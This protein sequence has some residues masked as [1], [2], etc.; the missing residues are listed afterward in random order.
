MS[1]PRAAVRFL[2][3]QKIWLVCAGILLAQ[4]SVAGD[5]ETAILLPQVSF[6]RAFFGIILL[7][8]FACFAI[9]P[10]F[11]LLFRIVA[12]IAEL[13]GTMRAAMLTVVVIIIQELLTRTTKDHTFVADI[14]ALDIAEWTLM[15]AVALF[16]VKGKEPFFQRSVI[17]EP[18]TQEALLFSPNALQLEVASAPNKFSPMRGE[19]AQLSGGE[20]MNPYDRE[21]HKIRIPLLV[22]ALSVLLILLSS[23]FQF[24]FQSHRRGSSE[25]QQIASDMFKNGAEQ[26]R[27]D[28]VITAELA[29]SMGSGSKVDFSGCI[30][31]TLAECTESSTYAKANF[32]GIELHFQIS[33]EESCG[34]Q[35]RFL[36]VLGPQG[37]A[38]SGCW[39]QNGEEVATW[40]FT[41]PD[42][43]GKYTKV[44]GPTIRSIRVMPY[45]KSHDLPAIDVPESTVNANTSSRFP[46]AD[47]FDESDACL[48]GL[49]R[50]VIGFSGNFT[51]QNR[52]AIKK[53]CSSKRSEWLC[54]I[55]KAG[56]GD[57]SRAEQNQIEI[58]CNLKN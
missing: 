32:D 2:F 42:G 41:P 24:Y 40:F 4:L 10:C 16:I 18:P 48:G 35:A 9:T 26:V 38:T 3:S 17:P 23:L 6:V 1:F 54:F 31:K 44:S 37:R 33:R 7:E 11:L 53:N 19:I 49:K 45:Y 25:Q 5:I 28:G 22:L 8:L 14:L 27:G 50:F 51:D 43:N 56:G 30:G 15:C 58:A 29:D 12:R 46:E 13:L 57:I 52:E 47:G 36:A 34:P 55:E 39:V 21:T 20:Q